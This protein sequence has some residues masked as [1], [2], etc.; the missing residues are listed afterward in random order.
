MNRPS[1]IA[2][3]LLVYARANAQAALEYRASLVS[4]AL[5]MALNDVMWVVFWAS[6]FDRFS[7]PGWTRADVV[8]LWAI[9]A[10][11]V[12]IAGTFFGNATRLAGLIARG[13]LDFFLTLP[14]PVL[15]HLLVSRMNLVAPGDVAFGLL[16]FGLYGH[17]SAGSFALFCLCALTGA[18]VVVSF[19]VIAGS[20]AF[21]LGRAE[22]AASQAYGALVTFSTY[23]TPIFKGA[24]RVI[25]YTLVPAAFVGA[26]PVELIRQPR[27]LLAA[28]LCAVAAA[29]A[30]AAGAVF[31][32][33]L[34]RYTSGNL[35]AMRD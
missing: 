11:S 3:M 8:T 33:G 22:S 28:E 19:C 21:W 17:P 20:L 26:V 14:K 24:A 16:A 12:G 32:A 10:A 15:L 4:Q 7:L 9:V 31:H 35:V 1:A 34:R 27:L 18:T 2:R 6:Y 23:P 29:T 25:L 30:A 5:A 13:E